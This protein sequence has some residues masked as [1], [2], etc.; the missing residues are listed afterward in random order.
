MLLNSKETFRKALSDLWKGNAIA[1]QSITVIMVTWLP[2]ITDPDVCPSPY[3]N[4]CLS[5]YHPKQGQTD[6][7]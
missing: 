7:S 5:A 4:R 6:L 1:M 3:S 2:S